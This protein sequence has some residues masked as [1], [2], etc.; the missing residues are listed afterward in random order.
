MSL[1]YIGEKHRHIS[2][3]F[4]ANFC[5]FV[6]DFI[7]RIKQSGTNLLMYVVKQLP[8][9][10]PQTYE[11]VCAWNT[12]CTYAE[13]FFPRCRYLFD[14]TTSMHNCLS[15][16]DLNGLEPS[17][18]EEERFMVKCEIDAAF[19]HLYGLR[20]DSVEYILESFTGVK[21]GDLQLYNDYRTKRIIL[22]MFN[23]MEACKLAKTIYT[24]ENALHTHATADTRA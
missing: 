14:S 4:A 22:A 19:F 2:L 3:I 23:S 6:F 11:E 16:F 15:E 13:W 8:I 18:N 10:Q 1:V 17:W 12:D 21:N 7:T 9:L 20:K 5:S 24:R